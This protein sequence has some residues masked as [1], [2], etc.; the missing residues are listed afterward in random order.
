MWK[1]LFASYGKPVIGI[2]SHGGFKKNNEA[3][4]TLTSDDLSVMLNDTRY[5]FVSLDYKD[6]IEHR[7]L[8]KFPFATQS[9][10]YDDTAALIAELD[11][12]IGVNTTAHHVAGALGVK[13]VT[14]VPKWHWNRYARE[15]FVWYSSQK[16][17][18]QKDRSWA[19]VI[20]S[21]KLNQF[22]I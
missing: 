1:A 2:T 22:F 4:R 8:R 21:I 13:T 6:G 16:L 17:I 11:L 14:L 15:S 18:H 12:V 7:R 19:D 3:G 20:K 5:E 9:K 10:D